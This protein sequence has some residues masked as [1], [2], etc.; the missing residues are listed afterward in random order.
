MI[1]F[2]TDD[3]IH[4]MDDNLQYLIDNKDWFTVV[5]HEK[6][7]RVTDYMKENPVNAEKIRQGRRDFYVFF[8][9]NDR[10]LGTD[11]LKIFPEYTD[12]YNLCKIEYENYDKR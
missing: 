6:F 4:Y 5:E 7:K 8:T 2:L 3:F 10:R 9:E 11:L 12:F 1:N